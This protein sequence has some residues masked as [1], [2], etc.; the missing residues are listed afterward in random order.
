MYAVRH[1]RECGSTLYLYAGLAHAVPPTN[2]KFMPLLLPTQ[3]GMPYANIHKHRTSYF[4]STL[5]FLGADRHLVIGLQV[6]EAHPLFPYFFEKRLAIPTSPF[7]SLASERDTL[8]S[9]QLRIVDILYIYSTC[10]FCSY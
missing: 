3:A 9:V 2:T 6:V 8:R 7:F 5:T 10:N 1:V 4:K